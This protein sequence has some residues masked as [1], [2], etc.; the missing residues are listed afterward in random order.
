MRE[1]P[2]PDLDALLARV[3]R[4][5]LRNFSFERR[6]GAWD[7]GGRLFDEN[8][9]AANPSQESE[10]VWVLR[11]GGRDWSHPIH[12]HFEEVRILTIDDV[13]VRPNVQ[14]AGAI[15]HARKDVIPL[16]GGVETRIFV[17][18]R[19][20]TGRYVMHC[21]NTVHEDHAM[22]LRFDVV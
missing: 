19:D 15:P 16:P 4:L 20:M 10:E 8:F 3:G 6:A 9:V 13:P 14:V 7:I 21:H 18:F 2:D 11:N 1:L 5:P 22:M 17:R 12:L